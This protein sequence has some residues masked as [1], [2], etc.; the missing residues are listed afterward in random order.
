M[1]ANIVGPPDV[2]TRISAI[3]ACHLTIGTMIV[4][5]P[6]AIAAFAILAH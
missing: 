3:A 2:A 1:R 4:E 5:V 6:V